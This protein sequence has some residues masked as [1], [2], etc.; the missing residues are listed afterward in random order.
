MKTPQR[1]PRGPSSAAP[2]RIAQ[3]LRLGLL[4]RLRSPW[5]ARVA[6]ASRGVPLAPWAAAAAALEGVASAGP[7]G[8]QAPLPL[9]HCGAVVAATLPP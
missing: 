9:V 1:G 8:R 3:R 5:R 7:A 4:G 2:R 6:N